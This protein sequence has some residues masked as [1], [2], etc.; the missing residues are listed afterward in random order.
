MKITKKAELFIGIASALILPLITFI[1]L[2]AIRFDYYT[3]KEFIVRILKL[4]IAGKFLSLATIPNLLLFFLFIK[5]N[6]LNAARGVIGS[7]LFITIII[8]IFKFI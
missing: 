6:K 1:I 2:H 4:E 5:L 8:L 7:T 3:L